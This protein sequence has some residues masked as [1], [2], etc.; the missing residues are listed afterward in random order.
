MAFDYNKI[1]FKNS[2][3]DRL[4]GSKPTDTTS[5]LSPKYK[6]YKN[7]PIIPLKEEELKTFIDTTS[8]ENYD[9]IPFMFQVGDTIRPKDERIEEF[10]KRYNINKKKQ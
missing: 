3:I 7:L 1:S 8:Q 5:T 2:I 6:N 9:K 10:K 4:R